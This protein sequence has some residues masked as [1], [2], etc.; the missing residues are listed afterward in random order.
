MNL[1][2]FGAGALALAILTL[3]IVP[4]SAAPCGHF[5]RSRGEI[6]K[7]ACASFE[8]RAVKKDR[9][10]F[11]AKHKARRALVS[12]RI[13]ADL[14]A[15]TDNEGRFIV[16]AARADAA[17]AV[18][19]AQDRRAR[20]AAHRGASVRLARGGE[21]EILPH[22]S[23]CP[24]RA[25]C[26]CG[27]A[28]RV[29]GAPIRALWLAANWFKFPPASPAPGMVSVRRHHVFV[30]EDVVGPGLVRAYDANSGRG[31]TRRHVRSLAGYSVRNPRVSG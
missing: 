18:A 4:A 5:D 21:A 12:D 24:R 10:H 1:R 29:F 30:I 25:F 28:V 17:G 7:V 22:P 20:R 8:G 19:N 27:A 15:T 26:G 6:V 11:R 23:G 31:L 2:H 14:G 3:V 9:R 13:G 16:A